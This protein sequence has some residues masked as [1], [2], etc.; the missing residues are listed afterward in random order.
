MSS[1]NDN[2][3]KAINKLRADERAQ[4][5]YGMLIDK[6][7]T[8]SERLK[9]KTTFETLGRDSHPEIRR[10]G[11]YYVNDRFSARHCFDN[12]KDAILVGALKDFAP[13]AKHEKIVQLF[14]IISKLLDSPNSIEFNSTT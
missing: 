14:A 8:L 4:K 10:S 1:S 12:E 2:D 6:G 3:E 7:F 9:I 5:A 13:L 11:M